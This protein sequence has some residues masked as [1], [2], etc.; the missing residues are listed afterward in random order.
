M[1]K[2]NAWEDVGHPNDG[3]VNHLRFSSA[4]R[5]PRERKAGGPQA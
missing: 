3:T 2:F 1:Y 5:T 4:L